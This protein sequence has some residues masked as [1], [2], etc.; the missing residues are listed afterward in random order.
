MFLISRSRIL[1]SDLLHLIQ[2]RQ[3]HAPQC[4]KT[5]S[6]RKKQYGKP[7]CSKAVIVGGTGKIG[8]ATANQLLCNNAKQVLLIDTDICKG[9]DAVDSLN[10]TFGKG[11][12]IF[13]KA[14]VTNKMEIHDALRAARGELK[15]IDMVINTFGVWNERKW[16]DQ[17]NVNFIGTLNVCEIIRDIV[18]RP[19][20]FVLNV[21][22]LPGIEVF[23]PSP[24]LA[25][26]FLGVV[27]YTQSVGHERNSTVSGIRTAALCCGITKSN[28]SKGVENKVCCSQMGSDLKKYMEDA[29]WQKPDEVG[30]AVVE[31]LKYAP[32]GSIWVVEG[33]RLFSLRLPDLNCFRKLENQFI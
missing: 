23:S 27:G 28:F 4:P 7:D 16:E 21:C 10:C 14:D 1:K 24:V 11:K 29:C 19:G 25:G 13:M 8:L 17:V 12:A 26:S 20:G 2:R 31:T 6:D 9:K 5:D 32:S 22:G 15:T 30:K 18:V 3:V 33:S